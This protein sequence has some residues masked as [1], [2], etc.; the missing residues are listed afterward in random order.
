[1]LHARIHLEENSPS[2]RDWRKSNSTGKPPW[3]RLAAVTN[4]SPKWLPNQLFSVYDQM[5]EVDHA[6][7]GL[8]ECRDIMDLVHSQRKSLGKEVDKYCS[9]RSV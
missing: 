6:I 9:E 7:D 2:D 5:M 8:P 3:A 1:M 4:T